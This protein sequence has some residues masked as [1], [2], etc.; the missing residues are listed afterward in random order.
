[1]PE[2]D[3][4]RVEVRDGQPVLIPSPTTLGFI[5]GVERHNCRMTFETHAERVAHFKRRI[6]ERGF[7]PDQYVIVLLNVDDPNGRRMTEILMPGQE[8]MWQSFRER[9]QIPFARGLAPRE[10]MQEVVNALDEE[11]GKKFQEMAGKIVAVVMDHGV[12]EVF[13]A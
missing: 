11:I 13:E 8:P 3:M 12:V 7:T 2:K 9:R 10:A 5:K 1:M 4:D 6:V